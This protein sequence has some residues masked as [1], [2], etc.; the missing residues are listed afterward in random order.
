VSRTTP[1]DGATRT[2]AHARGSDSATYRE[3]L[4]NGEYR[5]VFIAGLLSW[6]GDNF[7][8]AAITS[9]VYFETKSPALSAAAFALSFLPWL[10]AGPLL[11]TLAER[12]PYRNVMIA[13]DLVRMVLIALVALLVA[14]PHPPLPAM[15]VLLLLSSTVTPP[16]QAAKSAMMPQILD[17]EKLPVGVALNIS[18]GQIAQVVGYLAGGVLGAINPRGA[19]LLDSLTFLLSAILLTTW[20][21]RREP[22]EAPRRHLLRET[23]D[24]FRMVFGNAPMRSVALLVFGVMLVSAVPEGLAAAWVGSI[25]GDGAHPTKG[26]WQGI[27]MMAQPVGA[28]IGALVLTRLLN[29]GRRHR[30]LLPFA[31]AVPAVLAPALLKP[32]LVEIAVMALLCGI[33]VTGVLP[34]SNALFVRVLPNGYRARAFGVM[35]MGIQLTQGA[36][37]FV[38]GLLAQHFG[39]PIAVGIWS[40]FGLVVMTAI[41]LHWPSRERFEE[42]LQQAA[43]PPQQA[44]DPADQRVSA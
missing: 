27:V 41:A 26:L 14:L 39:P 38:A 44:T 43:P 12:Y 1:E 10:V 9:L 2:P 29:P 32:D 7:S 16:A 19:L 3:V 17:G 33:A 23:G 22:A 21:R 24:G 13:C 6:I 4:G 5:A 25:M 42:A 31:L 28:T 36:G 30:L 15:L 37:I 18:S 35:Q 20:V 8:K 40:V 11:A 34:T